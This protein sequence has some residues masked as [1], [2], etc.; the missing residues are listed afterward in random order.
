MRKATKWILL[1]VSAGLIGW[2]VIAAAIGGESA[3]ISDV[4]LDFSSAHP[5]IPMLAGVLMGHLFMPE[6]PGANGKI[7]WQWWRLG[8]LI[9]LAGTMIGL[10]F[11]GVIP[12]TATQWP[13]IAGLVM[14]RIGWPQEK[15]SK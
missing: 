12:E 9:A 6:K 8:G 7:K 10:D 2:D 11:G 4:T 5:S 14:G 13:L 3:T 15:A 1:A